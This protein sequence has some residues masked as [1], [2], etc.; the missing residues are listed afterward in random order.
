[1]TEFRAR[2]NA[3]ALAD[4]MLE[5]TYSYWD[6]S[7]HRRA[8]RVKKGTTIGRFLELV[9]QQ[10]LPEFPEIRLVSSDSLLYVKEDLIIPHVTLFTSALRIADQINSPRTRDCG[11]WAVS[12]LHVL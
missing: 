5:V 6:G 4:E 12:A 1:M 9:K 11:F 10:I 2:A 7:G 8:I 3:D